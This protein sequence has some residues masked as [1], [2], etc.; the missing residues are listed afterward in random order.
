MDLCNRFNVTWGYAAQVLVAWDT[1]LST[2]DT[3]GT[4][5]NMQIK[6]SAFNFWDYDT[7]LLTVDLERDRVNGPLDE[8]NRR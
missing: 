3:R 2:T 4:L 8:E 1:K 5:N 6:A 7:S